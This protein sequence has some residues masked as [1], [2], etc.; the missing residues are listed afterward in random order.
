MK[1][2]LVAIGSGFILLSSVALA[3]SVPQRPIYSIGERGAI[4]YENN[5]ETLVLSTSFSGS[6]EE[7]AWI[8]PTPAKPEI[9]K[10]SNELFTSLDER[11]NQR[12]AHPQDIY[13]VPLA[14]PS[15]GESPNSGPRVTVEDTK[16]GQKLEKK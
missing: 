16:E 1:K 10:V 4:F 15:I 3:Y 11:T 2:V 14:S 7:F 12:V 13:A 6:A 9:G 8:I 5:K